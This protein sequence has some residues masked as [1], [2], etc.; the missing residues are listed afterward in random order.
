MSSLSKRSNESIGSESV[1]EVLSGSQL[2]AAHELRVAGAASKPPQQ[3]SKAQVFALLVEAVS[4]FPPERRPHP[5]AGVGARMRRIDSNFNQVGSGFPTF[6][7]IIR[8]AAEAGY[9]LVHPADSGNDVTIDLAD[10]V[11]SGTAASY[12]RRLERVSAEVW[13]AMLSWSPG[14][15]YAFDRESRRPRALVGPDADADLVLPVI[16]RDQQLE[17]MREFSAAE[18]DIAVRE[19]LISGLAAAE[20]VRGFSAVMREQKNVDRRWKKYLRTHVLDR[21]TEWA[22]DSGIP[23][24]QL[25]VAPRD[26]YPSRSEPEP[27]PAVNDARAQIFAILERLPTSELL[28]LPIPVEYALRQ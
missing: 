28:R 6:R 21:A 7:D 13:R 3:Y 19:A 16:T 18:E 23:L 5:A 11:S 25:E 22:R 24:E 12:D 4:S 10:G 20:P 14:K 26:S 8:A 2:P 17:W 27:V 9:V 1:T 15:L